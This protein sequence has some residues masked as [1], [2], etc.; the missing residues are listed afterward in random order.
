MTS[1]TQAPQSVERRDFLKSM[2]ASGALVIAAGVGADGLIQA[3]RANSS[4]QH[5]AENADAAGNGEAFRPN[6]WIAI[7]A[8]GKIEIV[9]HRSEMG[10]GIRTSLPL[11]IADEMGA[12]WAD[13]TILQAIGDEDYGSQNTDGSRSVRRFFDIMRSAG[14]TA[15]ILLCMVAARKWS[16][17]VA[18]CRTED[19]FVIGPQAGQKLAFADLIEGAKV[20]DD[21]PA[22]RITFKHPR[23]WKYIGKETVRLYD[24]SDMLSGAGIY[25]ADIKLDGMKTAVIWRTPTLRGEIESFDASEALKIPGVEKVI[26]LP[27]WHSLNPD[28]PAFLAWGGIAV[29]ARNTWAALKGRDALKV[30]WKP[31]ADESF[32]SHELMKEMTQTSQADGT[33]VRQDGDFAEA[34]K[35][36]TSSHEATYT[37]PF[38]AHASMEPPVAVA[39]VSDGQC[40]VWAPTQNPQAAQ[41]T[42]QQV[43][44]IEDAEKIVVNVTLLGG[45][46]GRKSKPDFIV[47]AALVSK[48]LGGTPV[49]VQWTRE[50]D[51]RFD[52]YHTASAEHLKAGLDAKGKPQAWLQRSVFPAI[53]STFSSMAVQGSG[54]ELGLG[55]SDIPLDVPNIR[56]EV[57]K[58]KAPARIGWLRSVCHVFHAF[59]ECSFTD[60]LAHKA[61]RDPYEFLR[62]L[63]GEPRIVD[64]SGVEKAFA[65]P[66][67][68]EPL[69]KF[70]VDTGRLRRALDT[71]AKQAGWG[72]ALPKGRG[73]GIAVHRSFLSYVACCVEV[74]VER[75]GKV[76]IHRS[77]IVIDAGLVVNPD[78]VRAQ[79]EGACVFGAS[80]ALYGDISMSNG[81]VDQGNFNDYQMTRMFDAPREV[82]ATII[83]APD[84]PPAGVGEPGVPPYAPALCNAIFAAT[85]KRVRE[86]PLSKH[87]LSW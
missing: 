1:G 7:H 16:A 87:D 43:L 34:M 74:E 61:G 65:Y 13:V 76:I 54:M 68:G 64:L 59:A 75:S 67:H 60:E 86:L 51:I 82:Y 53:G 52:Y 45:G 70:P 46:F 41:Q 48:M 66:N 81:S 20:F 58:A 77:D 57:G 17:K 63:I 62:E 83:E 78:R 56:C 10:T 4:D 28:A 2:F 18:D 3:Q 72:R 85:G 35:S 12:D 40:E 79:I 44:Q 29:I 31:G 33:L 71:V 38:L 30:K 84:H 47:E 73:L 26:Q 22:S 19:S 8:S 80:L 9:A 37:V 55:F 36:A 25:G 6:L 42:L 14:A 15:R 69:E 5:Q 24:L 32:S 39:R 21:L 27:S 50:D 23:E 49:R 11:V